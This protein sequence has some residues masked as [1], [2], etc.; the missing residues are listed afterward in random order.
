MDAD[1]EGR[2]LMVEGR[3][4]QVTIF[5]ILGIVIVVGIIAAF[6]F[7]GGVDLESPGSLNPKGV[8]DKCVQDVVG[9]S[10]D[11]MLFNGGEIVPTQ[12]IAYQ[13]DDWNYLCYQA[14][15]YQGCYN[16]HPMLELQIEKEIVRDSAEGVEDCFD[17][18]RRDFEER[19]YDVEVGASDYSVDLLPGFV[20]INL[21][22]K[23]R[24]SKD[25]TSQEFDDFGTSKASAIYDLVGIAREVVNSEAQFCH[26]EY[27]GYMLLYPKYDIRRV[28]YM[29]SKIYRLID[30]RSLEEFKFAVRSC[31]LAPGV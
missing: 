20:E 25:G 1:L 8:V 22:K 9:E 30:R 5:I 11:K 15:Y 19:G 18:M 29:D 28:D 12:T 7:I 27:N 21:D 16:I 23:V 14:D 4:A 13:G 3:R 2:G 10:V 6:Y 24:V 17:F 31:A 26:F